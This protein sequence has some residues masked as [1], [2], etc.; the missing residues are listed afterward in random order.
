MI[1]KEFSYSEKTVEKILFSLVNLGNLAIMLSIASIYPMLH[2]ISRALNPPTGKP[3]TF[4]DHVVNV[5]L[6]PFPFYKYA[7]LLGSIAALACSFLASGRKDK[8]FFG[9]LSIFMIVFAV[10]FLGLGREWY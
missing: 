2:G 9:V 5:V 8:W 6:S 4:G 1:K 10:F 3:P 7:L